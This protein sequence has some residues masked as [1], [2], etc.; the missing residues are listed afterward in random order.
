MTAEHTIQITNADG[1][2]ICAVTVTSLGD[3]AGDH[4]ANHVRELV[5]REYPNRVR[6]LGQ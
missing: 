3:E 5:E 4:A 1:T 6:D 2:P